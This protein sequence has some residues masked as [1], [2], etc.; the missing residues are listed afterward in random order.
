M[1][2]RTQTLAG[3]VAIFKLLPFSYLEISELRNKPK[4]AAEAIFKGFYPRL[5]DKK[6]DPDFFYQNY[7]ET[8]IER[9]LRSLKNIGDLNAFTRFLK[10]CAGRTGQILNLQSLALDAG[11]SQ[12]TAKI[13]YRCLK[14]VISCFSFPPIL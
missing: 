6:I 7:I 2:N 5:Y 8:Y 9:D 1:E 10:L 11:I 4:N 12:P 14:R 13:G 3:R